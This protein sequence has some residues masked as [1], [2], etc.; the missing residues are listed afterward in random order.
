MKPVQMREPRQTSRQVIRL[1][2]IEV[3]P[4]ATPAQDG[5]R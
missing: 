2:V 4:A 1:R 3:E 5:L